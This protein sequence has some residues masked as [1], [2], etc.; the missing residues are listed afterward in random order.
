MLFCIH[1]L[2]DQNEVKKIIVI[3]GKH[4]TMYLIFLQPF[5]IHLHIFLFKYT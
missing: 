2:E 5:Y 3:C 4:T 1:I